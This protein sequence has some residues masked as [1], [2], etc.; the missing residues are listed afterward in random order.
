MLL[1][2]GFGA[3]RA[4]A[5]MA[6]FTRL[7]TVEVVVTGFNVK[8]VSRAAKTMVGKYV[9]KATAAMIA[10]AMNFLGHG[11]VGARFVGFQRLLWTLTSQQLK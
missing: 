8:G 4:L 5:Q 11:V 2:L 7:A 3:G 1:A 10:A 6:K 9:H